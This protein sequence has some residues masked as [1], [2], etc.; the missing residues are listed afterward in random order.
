MC[1][2]APTSPAE[3]GH[4]VPSDRHGPA[5]AGHSVPSDRH[6]PAEAGHSVLSRHTVPSGPSVGVS[7]FRRTVIAIAAFVCLGP[8][9]S[10]AILAAQRGRG[11]SGEKPAVDVVQSVGCVERR[12][13]NPE[14]WWLQ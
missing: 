13:G 9:Y 6:G 2:G 10:S 5:E 11:N 14:T 1:V 3:P 7:A 8:L 4:S 12:D